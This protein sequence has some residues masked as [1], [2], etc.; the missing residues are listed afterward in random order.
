MVN[1]NMDM[2]SNSGDG[3]QCVSPDQVMGMIDQLQEMITNLEG[4]L[5]VKSIKTRPPELFDGTRSK[6]CGFLTQLELYMQINR[7]KGSHLIA[8]I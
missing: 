6:L 8:S 7:C 1:N 5:Q 4:Q 2:G 3:T